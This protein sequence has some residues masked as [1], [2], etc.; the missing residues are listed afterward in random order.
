MT[1]NYY[2]YMLISIASKF[3][4]GKNLDKSS[5]SEEILYVRMSTLR[6]ANLLDQSYSKI[7]SK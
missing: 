1:C 4:E 6:R 7:S 2:Y 5:E 3:D